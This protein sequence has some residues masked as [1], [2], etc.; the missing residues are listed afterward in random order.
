VLPHFLSSSGSGTGSALVRINEELLERKVAAPVKKTGIND[1]RGIRRADHVTPLYPQQLA[2]NVVDMWR[3]LSL[4]SSLVASEFVAVTRL[5]S[6]YYV[7]NA[8]FRIMATGT[9]VSGTMLPPS[10][11]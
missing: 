2:L 8:V 3:S 5:G 1:R 6:V 10:S 7:N 11:G 9:S 4:Y